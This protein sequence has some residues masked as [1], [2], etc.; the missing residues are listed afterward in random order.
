M[1]LRFVTLT[2]SPIDSPTGMNPS[3]STRNRTRSRFTTC[4]VFTRLNTAAK[5]AIQMAISFMRW[6]I[7]R[8]DERAADTARQKVL[9][10]AA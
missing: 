8:Q 1:V 7:A 10:G 2:A 4:H 9:G 3:Q 5:R 6:L